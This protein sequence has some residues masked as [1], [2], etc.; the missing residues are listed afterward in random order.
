MDGGRG[1]I[2]VIAINYAFRRPI[3]GFC[4]SYSATTISMECKNYF[5]DLGNEEFNQIMERLGPKTSQL[6][7]VFCRSIT[8]APVI[9]NHLKDRYL[10]HGCMIV[11]FDDGLVER[12]VGLRLPGTSIG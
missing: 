9:V 11:L 10:R 6:G 4:G 5:A 3:Q 2:D 8:D 7:L 12:L 1:R